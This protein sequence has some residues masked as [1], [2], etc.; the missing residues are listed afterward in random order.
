MSLRATA[1]LL[2]ATVSPTCERRRNRG[3]PVPIYDQEP[4]MVP[5][6]LPKYMTKHVPGPS[7]RGP[8]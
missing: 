3:P 2:E 4:D 5:L 7:I 1:G 8:Q 6:T